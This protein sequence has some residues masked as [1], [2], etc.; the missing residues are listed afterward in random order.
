M[1]TLRG[2]KPKQKL[3][4][5]ATENPPSTS[6]LVTTLGNVLATHQPDNEEPVRHYIDYSKLSDKQ[7]AGILKAN[8]E[9]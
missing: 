5:T 6:V 4:K 8:K 3:G 1:P 7:L 9:N 2:K